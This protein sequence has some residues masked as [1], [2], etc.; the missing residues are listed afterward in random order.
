MWKKLRTIFIIVLNTALLFGVLELGVRFFAPSKVSTTY[1]EGGPLG[2]EDAVLGHK[3]NPN[4]LA[5]VTAPEF[6]VEYY[7]DADGFRGRPGAEAR[8]LDP[9]AKT[10]LLI[11]DSFTFGATNDYDDI[12]PKLLADRFAQEQRSVNIVNAGVPGYNTA[13]QALYLERLYEDCKPD[14]VVV[15][16]LPN[17][18]F[19]NEPIRTVEGT[20]VAVSDA[21]AVIK[22]GPGKRSTLESVDFIKRMMMQ[23]DAMYASLYLMTPRREFF[24]KPFSDLVQSKV[25]VTKDLLARMG[26]FATKKDFDL[27]FISVPQAFQVLYKASGQERDSVDA[28]MPDTVFGPFA[29][30]H[31][32][33]WVG[34][35]D[36][37]VEAYAADGEKLYYR[38]DGHFNPKGNRV[39]TDVIYEA[40]LPALSKGSPEAQPGL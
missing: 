22:A 24:E 26:N 8:A 35:L 2:Q 37:L 11:G 14:I 7:I 32:I 18:L 21:A 23:N 34:T 33:Q 5:R 25:D 30:D 4:T 31:N 20:D 16:F 29:A 15:M 9:E 38:Y 3:N 28:S 27:V 1:L 40:L 10:V 36:P 13:Q 19:A 12:W 6:E 17:D 39:V